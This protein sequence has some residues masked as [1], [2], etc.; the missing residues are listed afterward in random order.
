MSKLK[1]RNSKL[2]IEEVEVI[3]SQ[4][5]RALADYDNLRKRTETEKEVWIKFAAQN[6]LTRLLPTLDIL[7]S[8]QAHLKDQG[9]AIAISEFK[10][11]LGEE[12]LEEIKPGKGEVFDPKAHEAI[13]SIEGKQK[14]TVAELV[15]S[16]WK[17]KDGPIIRVAK[18]KVYGE[19]VE[20]KEEKELEKEIL[21]GD[22]V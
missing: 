14:G 10:R 2:K 13:E 19:K 12:G 6:L 16:G 18:V 7:E 1:T 17:F 22:Y 4:L 21:R 20:K 11:V 3:K 8:A 5:A 9:L 15:L